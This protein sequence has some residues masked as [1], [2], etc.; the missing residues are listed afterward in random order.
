MAVSI[1]Y[2]GL[3][4]EFRIWPNYYRVYWAMFQPFDLDWSDWDESTFWITDTASSFDLTDFQQGNE[5]FCA[6]FRVYN[7]ETTSQTFTFLI[8]LQRYDGWWE[9]TGTEWSWYDTLPWATS[10]ETWLNAYVLWAWVDVDEV[11]AWYTNYRLRCYI[12]W[13]LQTTLGFTT[14]WLN[15]DDTPHPAWSIRVWRDYLCYVP[16]CIYSWSSNNGYKHIIQYDSWY[17][18]AYAWTDKA[19][20]IWIPSSSSDH[21][22]YYVT[23]YGYVYRTM[24]T[25]PRPDWWSR[26]WTSKS[27]YIRMT[28][29]TTSLPEQTWYNYICYIDGWWYKRRLWVWVVS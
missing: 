15:I 19:G 10:E 5:V 22:I 21:H 27:W 29:S 11:R 3:W 12:N 24:E 13:D 20:S 7:H 25:Y 14:S 8:K 6:A 17:S 2:A 28:P 1:D 18:W 9:D 23:E 26:P 4:K 16:P